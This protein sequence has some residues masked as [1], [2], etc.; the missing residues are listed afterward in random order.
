MDAESYT[1]LSGGCGDRAP[2]ESRENVLQKCGIVVRLSPFDF[3][4]LEM[5]REGGGGR[6]A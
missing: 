6:F 2:I 5:Q 4:V 1:Y 3:G